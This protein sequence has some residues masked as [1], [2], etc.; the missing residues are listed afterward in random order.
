MLTPVAQVGALDALL[1][2]RDGERLGVPVR[3]GAPSAAGV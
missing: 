2:G 1:S 3:T